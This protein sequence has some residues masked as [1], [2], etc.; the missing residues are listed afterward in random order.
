MANRLAM[1]Q[2]NAILTLHQSEHSNRQ[3]ARMLGVNRETVG[4]YVALGQAQN[5]PNAPTGSEADGGGGGP[6]PPTGPTSDCE[7]FRQL[8]LQKMGQGLSAVR[9]HQDLRDEPGFSA[10]YYSVR[11][12][13]NRL[14]RK[15]DLPFRRLET[16]PGEEAQVDFGTG[17]PVIDRDGKRRRT[18]IF[19]IED[20][21][22]RCE[23]FTSLLASSP[24]RFA[25]TSTSVRSKRS[26]L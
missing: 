2:I 18:W 21:S 12:L 16:A 15:T 14:K 4:K 3:I 24:S 17:A 19:R 5:R 9:I 8:I 11:R 23:P 22:N 6:P 10:S 1:A 20:T 7:P 26:W 13:V 25:T